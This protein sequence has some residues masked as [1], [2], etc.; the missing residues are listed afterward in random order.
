MH[1]Y[2]E[3][4]AHAAKVAPTRRALYEEPAGRTA[5]RKI[6]ETYRL[7]P[8]MWPGVFTAFFDVVLQLEPEQD[9]PKLLAGEGHMPEKLATLIAYD[10]LELIN[11][12]QLGKEP[13][14]LSAQAAPPQPTH[15]PSNPAPSWRQAETQTSIPAKDHSLTETTPSSSKRSLTDIPRY[16]KDDPYREPPK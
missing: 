16:V 12:A 13:A 4:Q 14:T 3:R 11:T 6:F 8:D 15:L 1:T 2:E 5:L 10:L 9:L 7:H